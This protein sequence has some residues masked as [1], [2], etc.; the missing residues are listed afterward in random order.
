MVNSQFVKEKIKELGA[1]I[2]GFAP[3]SRFNAAPKGFHPLDIYKECKT[4]VAFAIKVP[5]APLFTNNLVPYSHFGSI[6]INEVDTMTL[7][8]VKTFEELGIGCVPIP[9]DD[10]YEHWEPE[11]LYGRAILSLR[12]A[13][14][15]A[16]L[17][18]LGKNTLLINEYYGNM[19]QLGAVLVNVD[20]SA[21]PIVDYEGCLTDC[22]ICLDSCPQ[23]ALDGITVNQ[24]ACRQHSIYKTEKGYTL[25]RCNV[26]RKICPNFSGI[27]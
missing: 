15:L 9:S 7:K 25:K 2:C 12:H 10:P 3:V 21:D 4:V 17:G 6:I 26:C 24:K 23:G 20:L 1:D 18:V 19:I 16:G 27:R 22:Q 11:R 13:G 5:L 14:Y 8:I